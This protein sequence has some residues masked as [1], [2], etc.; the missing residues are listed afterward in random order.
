MSDRGHLAQNVLHFAR[1]LRQAG[2]PVGTGRPL[3]ALRALEVAG[4]GSR[5]DLRAVLEACLIDRFEHRA[6]FEQAFAA[7][8][9]V[10][11]C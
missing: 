4:I 11:G 5:A 3:L 9:R 8:W 6:L 1:L 2:L 10:H 7:F